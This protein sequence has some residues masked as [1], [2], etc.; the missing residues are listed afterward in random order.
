MNTTVNFTYQFLK[1]KF[2]TFSQFLYDDHIKSRLIK[3]ARYFKEI[4]DKTDNMYPFERAEKFTKII[5]KLGVNKK[6]ESYLDQFRY[7]I[8]ELG[9]AMG[10][11]RMV[12]SGG[13]HC[14]S[15]AI[16]FR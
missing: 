16:R 5:R 11:I 15:N 9:N 7:L 2:F 12:R 8:T 10:Y 6:N 13:L 4:K 14:V 1:K 3:D